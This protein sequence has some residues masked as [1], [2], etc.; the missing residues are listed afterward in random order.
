MIVAQKY[1]R[2]L[3]PIILGERH[4]K[5]YH[6][7]NDQSEIESEIEKAAYAMVPYLGTAGP[8][9]RALCLG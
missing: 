7:N 5:R 9:P 4:I 2:V 1:L 8:W 3:T 6:V